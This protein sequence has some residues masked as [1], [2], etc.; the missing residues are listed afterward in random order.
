M[1]QT[2][3]RTFSLQILMESNSPGTIL[4][5]LLLLQIGGA[6]VFALAGLYVL[7]CL[8]RAASGLDRMADVAEAWLLMQQHQMQ[9]AERQAAREQ[10]PGPVEI[11]PLAIE[12][13]VS[14]SQN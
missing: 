13:P 3:K 5:L 12:K 4:G 2:E 1:R 6:L 11:V 10:T 8:N 7:Y 9:Q 14:D